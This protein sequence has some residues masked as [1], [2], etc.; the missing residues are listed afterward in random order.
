[1]DGAARSQPKPIGPTCRIWSAYTG[2]SAVA[3]PRRTANRSRQPAPR[4]IFF[5]PD[6]ID[7]GEQV[8]PLA[9]EHGP[10]GNL[11]VAHAAKG[12]QEGEFQ[13]RSQGVNGRDVEHGDEEAAQRGPGH[14]GDLERART[15]GNRIAQG[16]VGDEERG[17]AGPGRPDQDSRRGVGAEQRVDERQGRLVKTQARRIGMALEDQGQPVQQTVHLDERSQRGYCGV[18]EG[19]GGEC[20]I[21]RRHDEGAQRNQPAAIV[22]IGNGAGGQRQQKQRQHIH[23]SHQA[24]GRGRMGPLVNLPDG[25]RGDRLPAN[26]RQETAD[27]IL[28]KVG[29]AQG[30]IRVMRRLTIGGH[31][32]SRQRFTIHRCWRAALPRQTLRRRGART[33]ASD[34]A[35][36]IALMRGSRISTSR[37]A[38]SRM[39]NPIIT[40]SPAAG[41]IR[42]PS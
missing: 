1:M 33:I 12:E 11:E 37:A 32:V 9:L 20:D 30:G 39:N 22:P 5:S 28:A 18:P 17:D 41:A 14:G 8:A 6:E 3:P 34:A 25:D 10:L 19:Q 13:R 31:G 29:D 26:Q 24:Q 23:E 21:D 38:R 27:E 15:P 42:R 40:A 36:Q 2:S 35:R 16:R 7:A 4:M